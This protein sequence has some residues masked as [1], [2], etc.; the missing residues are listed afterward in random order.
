MP[1]MFMAVRNRLKYWRHMMLMDKQTEFA[2][3]LGVDKGQINRW[4]QH[5][6]EPNLETLYCLWLRLR[7]VFPDI[8]MQDLL[9]EISP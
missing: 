9:E 1:V 5:R 3:F 7:T 6:A 4:E 2:E 8:N